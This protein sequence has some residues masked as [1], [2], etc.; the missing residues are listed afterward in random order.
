M[1]SL[2]YMKLVNVK[3]VDEAMTVSKLSGG[4]QQKVIIAKWF[5]KNP[6][7]IIMDEPTKGI[8]VSAKVEIQKL[9]RTRASEGMSFIVISSEIEEIMMLCDRI[10]CLSDGVSTKAIERHE[11]SKDSLMDGI[12]RKEL[13][14][15]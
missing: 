11:F 10:V 1:T 3:A 14:N 6:T 5:S 12:M 2:D 8:D 15:A 9:I 13:Q 4:N 7:V